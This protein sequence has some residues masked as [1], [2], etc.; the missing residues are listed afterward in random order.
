MVDTIVAKY[1]MQAKISAMNHNITN[2]STNSIIVNV[3]EDV[4]YVFK[5]ANGKLKKANVMEAV[6]RILNNS[7]VANII[8]SARV[9]MSH[10]S[11][12]VDTICHVANG[13]Y[14]INRRQRKQLS[15]SRFCIIE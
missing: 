7:H 14:A 4:E 8:P 9:S 2:I 12:T 1:V 5:G 10:I 6:T 13:E 3:M 11:N 15:C